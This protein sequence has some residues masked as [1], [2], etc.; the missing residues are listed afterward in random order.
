[1]YLLAETLEFTRDGDVAWLRMNRPEK[2]N[3]FT[4]QMWQEMRTLGREVQD[5]DS[6]RALVVIGNGRAFSSGIDTSGVHRRQPP[7]TR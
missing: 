4:V 5:D 2:L 3:S 7:T 1:M 6:I